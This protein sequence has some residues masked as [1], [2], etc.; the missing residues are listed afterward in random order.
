MSMKK[1]ENR[2]KLKS[3]KELELE[4]LRCQYELLVIEHRLLGRWMNVRSN[5]S[6]ENLLMQ[7]GLSL[8][9]PLMDS[10]KSWLN[11]DDDQSEE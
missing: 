10:I 4:R 8:A 6:G 7:V 9:R 1:N 5:F 2:R 3:L 11:R